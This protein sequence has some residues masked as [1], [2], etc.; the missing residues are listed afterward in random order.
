MRAYRFYALVDNSVK[1]LNFDG[2]YKS[3]KLSNESN[4]KNNINDFDNA[5]Y[6]K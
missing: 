1:I 6:S 5:I 2:K 4:H 3:L